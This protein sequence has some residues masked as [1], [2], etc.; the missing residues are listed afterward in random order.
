MRTALVL[1]VLVAASCSSGGPRPTTAQSDGTA[2]RTSLPDA[3][4]QAPPEGAGPLSCEPYAVCGCEQGC[5]K[6]RRVD[7]PPGG[8]ER[9][10]VEEGRE[11]GQ[12]LVRETPDLPLHPDGAETCDESCRRSPATRR[13][14]LTGETCAEEP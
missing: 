9:F 10:R 11:A 5:L 13:C 8:V 7:G 6:V 3:G 12:V 2:A 14:R 1:F 4:R